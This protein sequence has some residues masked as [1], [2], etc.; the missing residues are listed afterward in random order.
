MTRA[1]NYTCDGCG[2]PSGNRTLA[3]IPQGWIQLE[4]RPMATLSGD[5]PVHSE[6]YH[7]CWYSCMVTWM[8]G[9][10]VTRGLV[11]ATVEQ[12]EKM[13]KQRVERLRSVR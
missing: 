5:H 8:L 6:L 2:K 9:R 1:S 4:E 11:I 12:R 7:F 13:E 10:N 3:E